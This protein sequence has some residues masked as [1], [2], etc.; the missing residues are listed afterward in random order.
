MAVASGLSNAAAALDVVERPRRPRR[1]RENVEARI[2]A[3]ARQLFADRGYAGTT[4]RE[5][6][7]TADVSETLLFR[8]YGDKAQLFDAVILTPFKQVIQEFTSAQKVAGNPDAPDLYLLVYD[9]LTQ[10]R[11]LL[12]A[13]IVG[14]PPAEALAGVGQ[15]TFEPFFEAGLAQL[16]AEYRMRGHEP[17]FDIAAGIRLSFG[18]MA[19]AVLMQ[20]WLFPNGGG[21]RDHLIEV[22]E[23]MVTRALRTGRRDKPSIDA[24][25]ENGP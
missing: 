19:S 12:S 14:R 4:T 11:D 13:L 20:E 9:L 7:H 6:A 15:F 2:R 25:G 21:D 16:E 24:C 17:D 18:M 3:A 10:N 1:T 8:Y 5:I 22:I 23:V